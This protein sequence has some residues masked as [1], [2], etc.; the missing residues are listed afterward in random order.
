MKQTKKLVGLLLA[1]MLVFTMGLT[2]FAAD[3]GSISIN[4]NETV[5]LD[6]KTFKAYK[7]LDATLANNTDS[8][9]GIAYTVPAEL[10]DFYAD[11]FGIAEDDVEFDTK[12]T[13]KIGEEDFDLQ[14]FAKAALAAAKAASIE[15]KTGAISDG[16]YVISNL[17]LG[18]YVIE[19]EGEATPISALALTTTAKNAQVDI[20]AQKPSIDKNI[21][22]DG[23]TVKYNNGAIGNKVP[24]VIT[25]KVP[26]MTGYSKYYFVVKDTM[27][28]GLTFN[29]DVV[30]KIGDDTLTEVDDYTITQQALSNDANLIKII[31]N[32]FIQYKDLKGT[33]IE[34][35]YSA[36][37]NE[38]V[39]I[40]ETG[41]ENEVTL[42]YSNNPNIVE[43]GD[44]DN[45]NNPTDGS[46]V[47]ETPAAETITYVTGIKVTKIDPNGNTLTG[48]EFEIS[49]TKLN[50][51]LVSEEIFSEDTN[52]EYYKLNDGTYTT[53][54][55]TTETESSYASTT[56]KYAKTLVRNTVEKAQDV[57]YVG[58]VDS[59]GVL[60]FEGLTAG[61]YTI[62][63]I[64][65]PEGYNLLKDEITVKIDWA[66]P[67]APSTECTWSALVDGDP[68]TVSDV[69]EFS[70]I[71]ETGNELPS[72]GGMGTTLFY[73]IGG[74]LVLG[75]AVMLVAKKRMSGE[76]I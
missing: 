23:S 25:S 54:E 76:K 69:V 74:V 47:G 30:V 65:A 17:P 16:K 53:T 1:L 57:Q 58:T 11:E 42:I 70:V 73:I 72:T 75:A 19:D 62:K 66:A 38:D 21:L 18:Y 71:N 4:G 27:S 3:D 24:Y 35:T 15:G 40:G 59:N 8:K 36:T 6:G 12:V 13:E 39:V 52:G 22:D 10:V 7:I 5:A 37:I 61:E 2:A 45:A 31:F 60:Y 49:G 28:K 67:V 55:P 46:P 56:V 26:D 48:A 44:P 51:V 63:E 9:D 43:G 64:K 29:D 50:T 20:K 14:E 32:N 33:D 41:N 68:A 34:I